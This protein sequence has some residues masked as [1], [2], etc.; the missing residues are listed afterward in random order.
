MP[1]YQ[2]KEAFSLRVLDN[3]LSPR[4][5]KGNISVISRHREPRHGD[6]V[7]LNLNGGVLLREY[8]YDDTRTDKVM[9]KT[10]YDHLELYPE[11]RLSILGV[12]IGI[13]FE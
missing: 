1:K 5:E 8:D 2:I 9:Y 4:L 6:I 10:N 7:A 13:Y 3:S 11:D 12:H